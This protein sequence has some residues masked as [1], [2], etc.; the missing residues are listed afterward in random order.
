MRDLLLLWGWFFEAG[1]VSILCSRDHDRLPLEMKKVRLGD[2]KFRWTQRWTCATTA[3]HQGHWQRVPGARTQSQV[4][5]IHEPTAFHG[6]SLQPLLTV[7]T[8]FTEDSFL[9]TWGL[10]WYA[11]GM[12]QMR[13]MYYATAALTGG[14]AEVLMWVTV[15]GGGCCKYRGSLLSPAAYLPAVRPSS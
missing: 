9:Q 15:W 7:G 13:Y 14:E 10:L 3:P 6:S 11:L 8:S 12:I 1:T 2:K 4:S 5:L